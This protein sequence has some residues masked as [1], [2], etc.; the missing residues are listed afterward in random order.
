MKLKGLLGASVVAASMI[1]SQGAF[2]DG[3]GTYGA[4][5][6]GCHGPTGMGTVGPRLA[7]QQEKYLVEQFQLIRDGKRTSGKS[8]MMKGAVAS[9]SDDDAKAIAAYLAAL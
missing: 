4:K 1:M 2:A 9:V 5:C 6:A 8:A 7:G 3:K